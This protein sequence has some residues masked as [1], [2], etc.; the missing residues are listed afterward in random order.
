[1]VEPTYNLYNNISLTPI[2]YVITTILTAFI[3]YIDPFNIITSIHNYIEKSYIFTLPNYVLISYYFTIFMIITKISELQQNDYIFLG[4]S[5]IIAYLGLFVLV[6]LM[7]KFHLHLIFVVYSIIGYLLFS[8]FVTP[9]IVILII[10]I[11]W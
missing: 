5:Y 4:I 9:L 6:E 10:K 2:K 11:L 8:P 1:M 3:I 7:D